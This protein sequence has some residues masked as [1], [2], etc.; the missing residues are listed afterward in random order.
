[1]LKLHEEKELTAHLAIRQAKI[2]EKV[3]I[4]LI[5]HLGKMCQPVVKV[6]DEVKAGQLIATLEEKAVFAPIHSSIS[7]KVSAIDDLPHPVLGRAKAVVITSDGLNRKE[8]FRPNSQEVIKQ[9][10]P[11]DIRRLIF[12]G[13]VVGMGGASFPAHIKL[14]PPRHLDSVILNGAEC[15]PYLTA[16]SRLMIE[17][18]QEIILGIGLVVKCTGARNVYIAIEDNKPEAISGFEKLLPDSEYKL[19][20]LKSQYPQ[21]GE[22]QLI[23]SVLGR[24]VPPGKLPFDVGAI[25][26]NVATVYAMYEAVYS[27]KPLYERAL[28][29]AGDCLENPGNLLVRIG[30]CIKDLMDECGPLR[31]EP[32]R[33]VFGGPMM[34]IAQ[35]SLNTPVIKS[36]NG[37]IFLSG[38]EIAPNEEAF[39]IRCGRCVESCPLGLTPCLIA[40]AVEKEKWDLA[41]AYGALECMECGACSYVCPQRRSIVQAIKYAK[42]RMPK[43]AG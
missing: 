42:T 1:M 40:L 38:K 28:T 23:K 19:K 41:K 17:K 35:Y 22:K 29:A 5:Q 36:S 4:P 7:G 26:H 2:P 12:D 32:Q 30:T 16:D 3:S 37:V 20:V 8:E 21:G 6:G 14:E 33:I 9:L 13:G 15:E 24:E 39:C 10:T 34:G 25:V 31:K 27:G 43:G 18:A 11:H